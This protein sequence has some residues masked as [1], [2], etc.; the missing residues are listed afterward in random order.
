MF[1]AGHLVNRR[2]LLGVAMLAY[3]ASSMQVANDIV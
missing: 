3:G 1:A 2:D